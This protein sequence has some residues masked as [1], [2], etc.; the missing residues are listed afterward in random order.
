MRLKRLSAS[1]QF[2]PLGIE[3]EAAF[4]LRDFLIDSGLLR[5]NALD[6]DAPTAGE[7]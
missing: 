6:K 2:S 5:E 1:E 4:A 3:E 7:A